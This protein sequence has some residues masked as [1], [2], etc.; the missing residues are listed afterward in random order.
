L[1]GEKLRSLFRPAGLPPVNGAGQRAGALP[2]AP[3]ERGLSASAAGRSSNGLRQFFESVRGTRLQ[4]LDLGG[5][6]QD[7][8]NFITA[9]GH[10]LYS[11]DLLVCLDRTLSAAKEPAARAALCHCFLHETLDFPDQHF[12]GVLVWDTLEFLDDEILAAVVGRFRAV[13][14]PGGALL[15][16]FHTQSKGQTVPIYRYQIQTPDTLR[17]QLRFN[18]P[19][20]RSFNNRHLERIFTQFRSVKFFLAKDGLREVIVTR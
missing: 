6:C 16:F 10:K 2:V 11:A 7:N 14:K 9:Q 1:L 15:S 13:V 18:R 8:I 17:L 20:P 12:D 3:V 5:A 19:L 4:I